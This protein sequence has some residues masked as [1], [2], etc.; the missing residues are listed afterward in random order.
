MEI[1]LP[2]INKLG[3]WQRQDFIPHVSHSTAHVFQ[4]PNV[5]SQH[6]LQ[7][8]TTKCKL[9]VQT[10]SNNSKPHPKVVLAQT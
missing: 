10:S 8:T 5:L 6:G 4:L 7:T 2:K 1:E 9:P 3:E